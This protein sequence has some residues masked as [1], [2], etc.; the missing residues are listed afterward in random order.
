MSTSR[1]NTNSNSINT[2]VLIAHIQ[3]TIMG[4]LDHLASAKEDLVSFQNNNDSQDNLVTD[5]T[6]EQ[7]ELQNDIDVLRA[8]KAK[9]LQDI[10]RLLEEKQEAK[11]NCLVPAR[12][13]PTQESTLLLTQQPTVGEEINSKDEDKEED[14]DDEPMYQDN[15]DDDD[16][17]EPQEPTTEITQEAFAFDNINMLDDED[18][19]HE[20]TPNPDAASLTTTSTGSTTTTRSIHSKSQQNKRRASKAFIMSPKKWRRMMRSHRLQS[21]LID[22]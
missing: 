7:Q 5:S 17:E 1:T 9:L 22:P 3:D 12:D 10:A 4:A 16:D 19:L 15:D 8:T 11:D 20:T 14:D 18:E 13:S 6:M 21:I 2:T